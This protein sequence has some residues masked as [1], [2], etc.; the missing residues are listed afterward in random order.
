MKKI[1]TWIILGLMLSWPSLKSAAETYQ[2]Q[3]TQAGITLRAIAK[4]IDRFYQKNKKLPSSSL[5]DTNFAAFGMKAPPSSNWEYFFRCKQEKCDITAEWIHKYHTV[6]DEGGKTLT[7]RL[8]F[9]PKKPSSI[10]YA[11]ARSVLYIYRNNTV[12]LMEQTEP[13][14]DAVCN[15]LGGR[16]TPKEACIFADLN[17]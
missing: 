2:A 13:V 16:V 14:S 17:N 11:E 5:S 3:T 9:R 8:T 15:Q 10:I 4:Q 12:F 6:E 7:L 1:F